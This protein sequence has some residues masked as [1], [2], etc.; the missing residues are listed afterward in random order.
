MTIIDY[1]WTPVLE[2]QYKALRSPFT[3]GR[4]SSHYSNYYDVI[5]DEGKFLAEVA[6]KYRYQSESKSELPTV[7]DWVLVSTF[8]ESSQAV[9]QDIFPRQ[10]CVSRKTSGHSDEVQV[11]AANIDILCIVTGLESS[12]G[13]VGADGPVYRVLNPSLTR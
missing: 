11:I 1:G 5:T 7:G 9:I 2:E 3:P 6:G 8:A 13:S 4:V 12:S 10:T